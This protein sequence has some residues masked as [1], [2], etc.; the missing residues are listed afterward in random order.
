MSLASPWTY[1]RLTDT[2]STPFAKLV[3]FGLL[4]SLIYHMVA[5][6]RHFF[7]DVHIGDSKKGGRLGAQIVMLISAVLIILTGVWLW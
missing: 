4:A 5:G 7:M 3:I 2:L 1:I 6:I